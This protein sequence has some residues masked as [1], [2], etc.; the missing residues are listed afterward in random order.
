MLYRYLINDSAV[1]CGV[2]VVSGAAL[3]FEGQLS[4]Y[5]LCGGPCYRCVFREPPP[6]ALVGSCS[7]AGVLGPLPGVIGTL[8]AL[9]ALK[10]AGGVGEPLRQRMLIFDGLRMSSRI[11]QLRE[12]DAACPACGDEALPLAAIDHCPPC[13]SAAAA[14]AASTRADEGI[15]ISVHELAELRRRKLPH[16][17]LDV[18]AENHFVICS[19]DGSMNVPFDDLRRRLEN[20]S[21]GLPAGSDKASAAALVCVICRRGVMSLRAAKLLAP[22]LAAVGDARPVRSVSG[23]LTAWQRDVDPNFPLY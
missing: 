20:D 2:P 1:A 19:L 17:L 14:A 8:Q 16:L 6:P 11:V 23:G 3:G 18:R 21:F 7:N 15:E 9:E 13:S 4:V 10:V 12:R 5:G 22:W